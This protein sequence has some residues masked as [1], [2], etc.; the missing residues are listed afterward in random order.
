MQDMGA[1]HSSTLVTLHQDVDSCV[2]VCVCVCF[3]DQVD[4]LTFQN[5][6]LRDR[7]KRCEEALP[8]STHEQI[9]LTYLST[10]SLAVGYGS[11]HVSSALRQLSEENDN[12]QKYLEKEKEEKKHLSQTNEEL[13]WW[14]QLNAG[15]SIILHSTN[16]S[17]NYCKI[18]CSNT[19]SPASGSLT[20][21][22]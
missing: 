10:V 16:P 11:H 7:A 5:H 13:L 6:S 2:C 8:R 19:C 17:D 14:L 12:L 3:K 18:C 15:V 9:W 4:T 1:S 20:I 22:C 21:G